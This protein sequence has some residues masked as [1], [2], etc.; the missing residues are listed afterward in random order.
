MKLKNSRSKSM[1]VRYRRLR[2]DASIGSAERTIA[3]DF[4][5]P[6]GSIRLVLPNGRKAR[7]DKD[8]AGLRRDWER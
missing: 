4:G 2:D 5:L 7:R 3:R 8:V 1:P 6:A